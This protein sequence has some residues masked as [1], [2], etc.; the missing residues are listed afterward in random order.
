MTESTPGRAKRPAAAGA[1]LVST[2]VALGST[3][4][5]VGTM[6][7]ADLG[8]AQGAVPP[9]GSTGNGDL[10]FSAPVGTPAAADSRPAVETGDA[11]SVPVIV[12]I[13]PPLPERS[14]SPPVAEP[15][16]QTAPAPAPAAPAPT[17][18]PAR[19]NGSR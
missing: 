8:A 13:P 19:S 5:I 9:S 6:V 1:R 10:E 16:A 4:L 12:L 3:A 11:V 15:R 17:A 18:P 2:G 7:Y 14:P